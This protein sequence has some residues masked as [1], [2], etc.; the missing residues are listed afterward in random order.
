MVASLFIFEIK[1]ELASIEQLISAL[2]LCQAD[3]D[4]YLSSLDCLESTSL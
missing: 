1:G 2:L 3:L 4:S